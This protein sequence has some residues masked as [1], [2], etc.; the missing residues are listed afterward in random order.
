MGNSVSQ[1]D[2][3]NKLDVSAGRV[4]Q[5]LNN[6]GNLSL[7]TVV[8]FA[9]AL[10]AKVSILGY[11]DDDPLNIKGPISTE[12][13]TECWDKCGR[14]HD[15]FAVSQ[16][17]QIVYLPYEPDIR[18]LKIE[19]EARTNSEHM[20]GKSITSVGTPNMRRGN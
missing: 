12:V 6:P 13:F 17:P 18:D 19:K 5:V 4:S 7:K 9:R 8:Q 1:V 3:A 11:C 20:A 15:Y 16:C 14:P 2:L 10:G